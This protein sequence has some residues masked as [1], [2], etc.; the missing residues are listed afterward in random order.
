MQNIGINKREKIFYLFCFVFCFGLLFVNIYNI[1]FTVHDDLRTY[2][3]V[4]NGTSKLGTAEC[5]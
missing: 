5:K 1:M 3:T 4:M 2:T